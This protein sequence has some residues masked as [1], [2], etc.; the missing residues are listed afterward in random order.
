MISASRAETKALGTA[1]GSRLRG[2]EA[3]FLYG[4]FGTGKTVFTKGIA[5]ALGIPEGEVT[6]PSYTLVQ[7]YR[8][9]LVLIHVDLY[10]LDNEQ[11]IVELAL[12]EFQRPDTVL[13]LEWAQHWP[14]PTITPDFRIELSHQGGDSRLITIQPELAGEGP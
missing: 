2:G 14:H 3:I 12:D 11:E 6:S 7:S 4:E 1:I 9:R 5:E 10:R 8:G 13:V